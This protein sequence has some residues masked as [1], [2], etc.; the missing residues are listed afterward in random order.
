MKYDFD[1]EIA[2][3]VAAMP[4]FEATDVAEARELFAAFIATQAPYEPP[5]ALAIADVVVPGLDGGPV[6]PVRVYT[7]AD[8]SD[9][10]LPG[11]LYL[12]G[13]GFSVGNLDSEHSAAARVAAE[14]KTVVVSVDY[15]LAPEHPFPA[16][17]DDCYAALVWSAAHTDQLGVDPDRLAVRGASAGGGLAAAVAL[18]ARDRHGPALCFQSLA[19][20]ELDDRLETPSMIEFVDTPM[21]N[22]GRAE[23]SWKQYLGTEPGGPDVSAYAA[24][25]RAGDL[26][27][28]PAAYISVCEFDPLRDEGMLYALR[29]TQ[30]GVHTELHLYPGTFHGSTQFADADIS[31][32]MQADDIGALRR[33]LHG[34]VSAP[35]G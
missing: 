17:L 32:R 7:P 10:P 20:P 19:I 35:T 12:H 34:V 1:P 18:L 31:R 3:L 21:W 33:G 24:P 27:G 14:A 25:A 16:G 28:L 13:G 11:T 6:V 2:P 30:A 4:Q 29:L 22:R 5:I 8:R 26:S 9:D 15:R 23:Q